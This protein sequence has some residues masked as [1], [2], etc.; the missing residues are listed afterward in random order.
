MERLCRLLGLLLVPWAAGAAAPADCELLSSELVYKQHQAPRDISAAIALVTQKVNNELA[1]VLSVTVNYDGEDIHR[2]VGTHDVSAT[3]SFQPGEGGERGSRCFLVRFV[4]EDTDECALHKGHEMRH[5]CHSSATCVNTNGSY[6]CACPDVKGLPGYALD[7][8]GFG[9]CAG[10]RDSRKCCASGQNGCTN[11]DCVAACASDFRCPVDVC[12][13]DCVPEAA[14]GVNAT[15]AAGFRCA[16]PAGTVGSGHRCRGRQPTAWA[17]LAKPGELR[18][19]PSTEGGGEVLDVESLCGCQAPRVD[20]CAAAECGCH[21][22]C[23]N[24]A[25][26]PACACEEGFSMTEAGCVDD[27]LPVLVLRGD[28][29]MEL[30]Q[31]SA[32]VEPG[33]DI[34]DTNAEDYQRTLSIEY[35]EPLGGCLPRTGDFTVKYTVQTNWTDPP[36]VS[37]ER[38]V[39]VTDVDE[40]RVALD[41]AYAADCKGCAAQCDFANGASCVNLDGT[42]TCE[43]PSCTEGDGFAPG[44]APRP[45]RAAPSGFAGGTGCRDTCAPAL[46]LL[47]EDPLVLRACRGRCERLG[48]GARERCGERD[49]QDELSELLRRDG[50]RAFCGLLG[51]AGGGPCARAVDETPGGA[52]DL[53]QD[54]VV[55]D[56]Q[57]VEDSEEGDAVFRVPYDVSDRHGNAAPTKYRTVVIQERSLAE[58]EGRLREERDAA[59]EE[60]RRLKQQLRELREAQQGASAR[61]ARECPACPACDCRRSEDCACEKCPDPPAT[62]CAAPPSSSPPPPHPPAS[63]PRGCPGGWHAV[64]GGRCATAVNG[65][66]EDAPGVCAQLGAEP[67]PAGAAKEEFARRKTRKAAAREAR[68][69]VDAVQIVCAA[70][71]RELAARRAAFSGS[72]ASPED[73]HAIIKAATTTFMQFLKSRTLVGILAAVLFGIMCNNV[74]QALRRRHGHTAGAAAARDAADDGLYRVVSPPKVPARDTPE[75]SAR[76]ARSE[77]PL[78]SASFTG[79]ISPAGAQPPSARSY[80]RRS[81]ALRPS[82]QGY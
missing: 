43:C 34:V 1:G 23:V 69:S 74:L 37:A 56:P 76:A 49:W 16:C 27:T 28:N 6:Y 32:Y 67:W 80:A 8:A 33:L 47:G 61:R 71:A 31:C 10:A 62:T 45:D 39:R 19:K 73:E 12:P 44:F 66:A 4:I 78:S 60:A 42:Y 2:R 17:S 58:L 14:C 53:S 24:G 59:R 22:V 70:S 77:T 48:G 79:Q 41:A 52:E 68:V 21:S 29:P 11:A 64:G 72:T 15:A 65:E 9:A 40:C 51:V 35:S 18:S 63:S 81:G 36:Y 82:P 7:G 46:E 54:V 26:G 55:G 3:V 57:R 30:R 5:R 13:G 25:E 38:R 75:T 20:H 50:G